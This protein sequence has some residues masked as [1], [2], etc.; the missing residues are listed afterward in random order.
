MMFLIIGVISISATT[1]YA[2]ECETEEFEDGSYV[3]YC[4]NYYIVH[5]AQVPGGGCY[6]PESD[7]I[8][9]HPW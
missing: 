5:S 6:G 8:S 2:F 3:T 9:I 4:D 7:C 1:S